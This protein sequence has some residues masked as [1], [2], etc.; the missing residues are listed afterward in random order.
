M[1]KARITCI[2]CQAVV[3]ADKNLNKYKKHL[4]ISHDIFYQQDLALTLAFLYDEENQ[5]I[6]EKLMPRVDYFLAEGM[7]GSFENIFTKSDT[8][9]LS[10]EE[11][12]DV[13]TIEDENI[14][15]IQNMLQFDLSDSDDDDDDDEEGV[16]DPQAYNLS[17]AE[18][19][20][21]EK[22]AK[23][24]VGLEEKI[25]AL[26]AEVARRREQAL[27]KM[28]EKNGDNSKH[29]I[30]RSKKEI[31]CN[32]EQTKKRSSEAIEEIYRFLQDSGSSDDEPETPSAVSEGSNQKDR[33]GEVDFLEDSEDSDDDEGGPIQVKQEP[34][35]PEKTKTGTG[36][37]SKHD[38][39]LLLDRVVMQ[40]KNKNRIMEQQLSG[41]SNGPQ[42]KKRRL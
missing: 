10:R 25:E 29:K 7:M 33:S 41:S 12:E 19:D 31:F 11:E 15:S 37:D 39:A 26:N 6:V 14:A 36:Q 34:T 13:Q 9:N 27:P 23:D 38:L 20:V 3:S 16:D 8:K 18:E 32:L 24:P 17:H 30:D 5:T 40:T 35:S 2:F 21:A 28:K 4:E 42:H 1:V 22:T